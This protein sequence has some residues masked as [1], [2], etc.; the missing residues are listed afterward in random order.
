MF[1][2]NHKTKSTKSHKPQPVWL[3][4]L[5]L[6]IGGGLQNDQTICETVHIEPQREKI[7]IKIRGECSIIQSSPSTFLFSLNMTAATCSSSIKKIR[8]S[9]V[10]PKIITL[11]RTRS[12]LEYERAFSIVNQRD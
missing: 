9:P 5:G 11:I 10:L 4:F 12:H 7:E 6:A 3:R 8:S 2:E 1:R